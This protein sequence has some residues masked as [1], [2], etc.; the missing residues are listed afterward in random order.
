MQKFSKT[1]YT[2]HIYIDADN[3]KHDFQ[4]FILRVQVIYVN[5]R[6]QRISNSFR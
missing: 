6:L 1:W 5:T 4:A 2:L 3:K